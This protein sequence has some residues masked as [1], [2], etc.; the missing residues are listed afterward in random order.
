[1]RNDDGGLPQ[2]LPELPPKDVRIHRPHGMRQR[3]G[4]IPELARQSTVAQKDPFPNCSKVPRRVPGV[5]SLSF[6]RYQSWVS[7][8]HQFG[9]GPD[10]YQGASVQNLPEWRRSALL[11][12]Y[13]PRPNFRFGVFFIDPRPRSPTS[14][15][16]AR[17]IHP[18]KFRTRHRP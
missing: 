7:S 8:Y 3:G 9:G 12:K 15:H 4:P 11:R 17:P 2:S 1:M 18:A 16:T 5:P 10:L 14:S 6:E 13:R